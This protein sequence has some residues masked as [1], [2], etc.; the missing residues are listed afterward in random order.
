MATLVLLLFANPVAACLN[1][2]AA[3]KLDGSW[4]SSDDV[5]YSV[6]KPPVG[7][8]LAAEAPI[9]RQ[10]LQQLNS[11]WNA[12]H[13]LADYAGYGLVLVYLGRYAEARKVFEQLDIWQPNQYETAANLGTVYELLGL[14]KLALKWIRRSVQLNP[15]SHKGTEWLHIN[16]LRAK[17]RGTEAINAEYLLGVDFGQ[18]LAPV[19]NMR[20]GRLLDSVQYALYY[21][22]SE[23]LSFVH[24]PDP[25]MA[26]LLFD[27]GNAYAITSNVESALPVYDQ[28][29]HFGF[30]RRV[31]LKRRVY[32][33][34]L[35]SGQG[36]LVTIGLLGLAGLLGFGLWQLGKADL[37]RLA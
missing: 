27:L 2:H 11:R 26:E 30:H 6:P 4:Q 34:W 33:W 22:L 20:G 8:D 12:H 15:Q 37:R 23:R 9:N 36:N 35:R 14:N 24:S 1:N 16:I 21:Q 13:R 28:A 17:L 32:F 19:S 5:N 7:R 31:L 29:E 25:I 3:T 18:G 10:Y